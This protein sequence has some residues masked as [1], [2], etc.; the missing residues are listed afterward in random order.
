[1]KY[2]LYTLILL[3]GCTGCFSATP[4]KQVPKE[5]IP[6][7][8]EDQ[9]ELERQA[10]Y[11]ISESIKQ[12]KAEDALILT[13]ALQ[14]K[15]GQ[16]TVTPNIS[17]KAFKDLGDKILKGVKDYRNKLSTWQEQYSSYIEFSQREKTTGEK[18]KS[19][20]SWTVILLVIWAVLAMFIENSAT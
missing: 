18:A 16:P 7:E 12:D 3:I 10:I 14:V 15:S 2:Y 20:I 8:T 9:K 1:M 19:V 5:P 4:L 11:S 6:V 13:S 17:E